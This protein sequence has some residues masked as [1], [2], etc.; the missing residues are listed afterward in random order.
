MATGRRERNLIL[1]FNALF[2]FLLMS[3]QGCSKN[4]PSQ[5]PTKTVPY[6][7]T[8]GIYELDL[9]TQDVRLIYKTDDEIFASSL[10]LN[11]MSDR[12]VFARKADGTGENNLEIYSVNTEGN[13]L[14][15]LT[16][17]NYWDLY[18]V[19]SPDDSKIAYLSKR[20]GD[21]DIYVMDSDG[22]N[23]EKLFDSGDNDADIDWAGDTIVFTSQ[24]AVWK[25]REDGAS[26]IQVTEPTGRGEWG[27]ANLPKGDYDP[28]VSP[29][30][31]KVVFERLEDTSQPNGG[32]NIF[33][34]NADGTGE[35]RLTD[36]SY[37]QGLV[38]WSH[39]GERLVYVVAAINGVGEYDIYMM[40]SDGTENHNITPDYFP[41][42]FLCHSPVFS[43]DDSKI[44]FIGQWW[45]K[46]SY[47]SGRAASFLKRLALTIFIHNANSCF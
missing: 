1:F 7:A 2:V 46:V 30:G 6:G 4:S 12:L 5:A 8:W 14:R 37:A 44:F 17:N 32:Y 43:K 42:D 39:L 25:I 18:P 45:E 9:T 26:P 27:K 38:S 47:F 31:K 15:R 3:G 40:N 20:E 28:R 33:L 10:R 35:K 22:S 16:S 23:P 41:A 34:V 29:N 19:W 13:D 24:Y 36:S 11:N 21:L